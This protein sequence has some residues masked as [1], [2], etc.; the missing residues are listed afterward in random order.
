VGERRRWRVERRSGAWREE[1]V[2]GEKFL[3]VGVRALGDFIVRAP[4]GAAI[5]GREIARQRAREKNLSPRRFGASAGGAWDCS[6][7]LFGG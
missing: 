6:R 5:F 3:A 2:C 4:A 7:M 1:A